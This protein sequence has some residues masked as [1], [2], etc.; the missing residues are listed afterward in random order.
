[1]GKWK[2]KFDPDTEPDSAGGDFTPYDGPP[3]PLSGVFP[4]KLELLKMVKNKN[5]D[6]MIKGLA[7]VDAP[8]GHHAEEYNGAP[9]WFN[10]NQT[11]QGQPYTK[12]FLDALGVPWKDFVT[13]TTLDDEDQPNIVRL[14]KLKFERGKIRVRCSVKAGRTTS[15]YPDPKASPGKWMPAKD[16]DYEERSSKNGKAEKPAKASKKKGKKKAAEDEPP[17]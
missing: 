1:M 2:N 5:K 6:D 15:E 17:F 13:L 3:L 16:E 9:M 4:F 11:E 12:Q 10:L 14:G 8:D 7:V